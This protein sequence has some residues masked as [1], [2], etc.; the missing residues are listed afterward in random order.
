PSR[1][2]PSGDSFYQLSASVSAAERA[3]NGAEIDRAEQA[4]QP[5]HEAGLVVRLQC[6]YCCHYQMND[7]GLQRSPKLRHF[8][9][10]QCNPIGGSLAGGEECSSMPIL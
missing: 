4:P 10:C 7:S 9:L 3:V 8:V 1:C 5:Q 6:Q 2:S